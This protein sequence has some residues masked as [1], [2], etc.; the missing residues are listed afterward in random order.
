[1]IQSLDFNPTGTLLAT[2]SH[3]RKIRI[4]ISS[5]GR[6]RSLWLLKPVSTHGENPATYLV[7]P[8]SETN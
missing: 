5:W 2:T 4:K 6:S 1:M 8:V 7:I 3:D